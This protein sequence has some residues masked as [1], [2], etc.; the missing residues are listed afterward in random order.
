MASIGPKRAERIFTGF[1]GTGSEPG[2][3]NF[4]AG[5]AGPGRRETGAAIGGGIPFRDTEYVQRKK[6]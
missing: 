5:I 2:L 1:K 6:T 4:Q 3:R